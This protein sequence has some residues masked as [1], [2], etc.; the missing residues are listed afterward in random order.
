DH[1]FKSAYPKGP[2]DAN[3]G[4]NG[5]V[6][7][8]DSHVRYTVGSTTLSATTHSVPTAASLAALNRNCTLA[9]AQAAVPYK[10]CYGTTLSTTTYNSAALNPW[11]RTL[12]EEKQNVANWYS[13]YRKRSFV[14]K[15]AIGAVITQA[16]DFR[17]GLSLI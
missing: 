14:A 13:Y 8:W 10:D 4:P 7:L 9:R 15:A 12:A 3:D 11:G 6:D 2:S 17:Y 1:G 5:I 16:N